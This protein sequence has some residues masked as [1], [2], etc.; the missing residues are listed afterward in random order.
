MALPTT[1]TR[2][3][4]TAY[5]LADPPASLAVETSAPVPSFGHAD[6]LVKVVA[7]PVNPA[8][9][10]SLQARAVLRPR[11]NDEARRGARRGERK[12][13][14]H[15][16]L[17]PPPRHVPS[18]SLARSDACREGRVPRLRPRRAPRRRVNVAGS[19]GRL[20]TPA[21]LPPCPHRP[22]KLS[23][24]RSFASPQ[25]PA[26]KAPALWWLPARTRAWPS[27]RAPWSSSTPRAATGRGRRRVG[28][29]VTATRRPLGLD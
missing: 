5:N 27:A 24:P 17:R 9:V 11:V 15:L 26:S 14:Q 8:D 28:E 19:E 6:V 21:T 4:V 29:T 23:H 2:V 13:S 16:P 7:R 1:M 25:S 12:V 22:L 20:P 10:F 18:C 3:V